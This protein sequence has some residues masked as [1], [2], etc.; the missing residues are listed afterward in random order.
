M[1]RGSKPRPHT[2]T[3]SGSRMFVTC[4]EGGIS[5]FIMPK[6]GCS[7]INNAVYKANTGKL[8]HDPS[9]IH[10]DKTAHNVTHQR[11]AADGADPAR[12]FGVIRNPVNRFVSFYYDKMFS[13]SDL[14]LPGLRRKLERWASQARGETFTIDTS[15]DARIAV[16]R[17][18]LLGLLDGVEALLDTGNPDHRNGHYDRQTDMMARAGAGDFPVAVLED[19]QAT[20]PAQ[21]AQASPGFLKTLLSLPPINES[22]KPFPVKV[23]VSTTVRRRI[24]DVYKDDIAMYAAYTSKPQSEPLRLAG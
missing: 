13:T 3:G 12:C 23:V 14:A 8:F 2:G 19:L 6:C 22:R 10:F 11:D 16:H 9:R 21:I 7:L 17:K 5:A 18:N 4:D 20:F 24:Q 15:P 1:R